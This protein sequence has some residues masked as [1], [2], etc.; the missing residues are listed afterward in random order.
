MMLE[1]NLNDDEM[2]VEIQLDGY[3]ISSMR[4]LN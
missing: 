4:A 2:K 1:N 3:I